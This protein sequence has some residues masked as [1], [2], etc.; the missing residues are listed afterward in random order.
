MERGEIKTNKMIEDYIPLANSIARKF[1]LLNSRYTYDE[2][3]SMAYLGLTKA[4]N[5]FNEKFGYNPYTYLKEYITK[6][7]MTFTSRDKWFHYKKGVALEQQHCYMQ[8]EVKDSKGNSC[9]RGDALYDKTNDISTVE[10]IELIRNILTNRSNQKSKRNINRDAKIISMSI[11]YN[12]T[13]K[14]ISDKLGNIVTSQQVG[15]I[16]RKFKKDAK[17][18]IEIIN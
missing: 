15:K 5:N 1:E 12:M 4:C 6:T 14:D 10:T 18:E 11:L 3:C 7:I 2:Y 9:E 16:V 13:E 8:D 17:E